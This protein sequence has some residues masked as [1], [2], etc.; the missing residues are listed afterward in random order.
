MSNEQE[1]PVTPVDP[2]I[3]ADVPAE[4]ASAEAAETVDETEIMEPELTVE[5]L[6][7]DLAQ[8]QQ[9]AQENWDKAL[10]IQAEME[11]LKRRTQKDL[12]DAHK[13]ALTGFAKELL[14]VLDSLVL[15]L[16]AATGD[17]EQVQ[18][19]REGSE[20]TI[21]QF[22]AALAKFNVVTIDPV[23]EPFNAEHH[24][25]MVMQVVEGAVPNTVVTVF[26]KGYLLNGRLL[27]PAMVVVAKAAD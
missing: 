2:E 22:E 14:P 11:N 20:L 21:K 19:F 1:I 18:K 3:Q 15:G 10:R 8:A 27:R 25:A 12:E 4:A 26:Q 9:K 13:F 16:Q 24:Q 5:G 23:G 7:K 6:K 17:S